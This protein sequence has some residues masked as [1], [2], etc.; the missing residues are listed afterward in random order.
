VIDVTIGSQKCLTGL[1]LNERRMIEQELTFDNP[2]YAQIMKYSKWGNTREP[3][4]LEYFN[5]FHKDGELVMQVPVGY[6]IPDS[7]EISSVTDERNLVQVPNFPKFAMKLRDTQKEALQKYIECNESPINVSGS[8]QLPTGKGKTILGLAIAEHYSCRTLVIVHKVDLVNGWIKNIKEAFDNKADVGIIR[9]SSRKCGN[10][11]T[12]ATIQTLNRMSK[13]ELEVLYKSFGLIIQDEMHHC[14]SSSFSLAD[15]FKSRYRL[16]LTATPER[17][18]GLTHVMNLYYGDFCFKYGH[19]KEDKDILSVKVLKRE[20][21]VFYDPIVRLVKGN[22]SFSNPDS[23]CNFD[24]S[25][26]PKSGC[27]RISKIPYSKRPQ[28]SHSLIDRAVVENE[29]TVDFICKDILSEYNKGHSCIA[30]FSGVSTVEVYALKLH[31]LGVPESDIGLYYGNNKNCDAVIEKAENKRKFI[32]LA[33]YSKATEGTDVKQWE[34][35]FLVS[36]INTG[37]NVE[38]AVGRIR[39]VKGD[40]KLPKA[41]LYDYRYSHCYQIARHGET[42]DSRY[43]ILRF[44]FDKP[45]RKSPIFSKGYRN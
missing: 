3:Q 45:V 29:D 4:Y 22:Y 39:R 17:S 12:V 37:K 9:A 5:Y 20:V 14:P 43:L 33:T 1:T 26:V 18:D 24:T 44:D 40:S 27:S 31:S 25:Y 6:K 34:V 42:R 16:G 36:S 7:I 10:H 41:L 23:S 35:G 19:Q 30:F 11:F 21:P 2:K 13:D 28:I 32:T 38:Q 8:I 15:N